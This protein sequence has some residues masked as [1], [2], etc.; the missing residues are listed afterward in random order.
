MPLRRGHSNETISDNVRKLMHEGHSAKR[1]VAIA[2]SHARKSSSKRR[3]TRKSMF[4]SVKDSLMKSNGGSS[5]S[6]ILESV[7]G[8]ATALQE[9]STEARAQLEKWLSS[10]AQ[11]SKPSK[12]Q[13]RVVS[14]S[15][16]RKD[17]TW[18]SGGGTESAESIMARVREGYPLQPDDRKVVQAAVTAG[19]FTMGGED[20]EKYGIKPIKTAKARSLTSLLTQLGKHRPKSA[21]YEGDPP[22]P[23]KGFMAM[24]EEMIPPVKPRPSKKVLVERK[25]SPNLP[26]VRK[27]LFISS[28][29]YL[30]KSI[31]RDLGLYVTLG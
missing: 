29:V 31:K 2:L 14:S 27:S 28:E 15:K 26:P 11:S 5:A 17:P 9:L 8:G 18:L 30:E 4:I 24:H 22:K 10:L 23:K 12:A 1:A 21:T 3:R 19:T 7:V 6:S 25:P 13:P 16:V 20:L